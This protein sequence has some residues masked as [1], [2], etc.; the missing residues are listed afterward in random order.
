MNIFSRRP[1]SL[2]LCIMLGGFSVFA[3]LDSDYKCLMFLLPLFPLPLLFIKSLKHLRVITALASV[4]LLVSILSSYLY[5]DLW[6]KAYDR[7]DGEEIILEGEVIAVGASEY[8]STIDIKTYSINDESLTSYKIIVYIDHEKHDLPSV[9][10]VLTLSGILSGFDRTKSG[11][12]AKAYYFSN[13]YNAEIRDP[14]LIEITG[15]VEPQN[16]SIL[17]GIRNQISYKIKHI[18]NTDT[19]G[20]FTALFLGDKSTLSPKLSF[21]FTRIG[22][23]HALALSGMHL[24]IIVI[25]LSRLTSV[26]GVGKKTRD[27]LVIPF[28]VFYM[29]LTGMP[30]S[31]VRAGLMLI[32]SSFLFLIAKTRDSMTTLLISVSLICIF[33]PESVFDLSLWLSAFATFGIVSMSDLPRKFVPVKSIAYKIKRFIIASFSVSFYAM[34]ATLLISILSFNTISI[35]SPLSTFI[36][37][38]PIELFLYIGIIALIFGDLIPFGRVLVFLERLISALASILSKHRF[39][40]VSSEFIILKLL[41]ILFTLAFALFLILNIKRKRVALTVLISGFLLI[42]AVSP[43]LSLIRANQHEISYHRDNKTESIIIIGEGEINLIDEDSHTSF[44]AYTTADAAFNEKLSYIDRYILTNYSNSTSDKLEKIL[45]LIKTYELYIPEPK[46]EKEKDILKE[47]KTLAEIHSV[48]II[49][50]KVNEEIDLGI[51]TY[52]QDLRLEFTL[53]GSRNAF[54]LDHNGELISYFSSNTLDGRTRAAAASVIAKSDYVIFGSHGTSYDDYYLTYDLKNARTIVFSS[55]NMKISPY[56]LNKYKDKELY[57]EP[58]SL[59][60]IR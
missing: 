13:G 3:L 49:T 33:N 36:F 1:L 44:S 12:D 51:C 45:S 24:A 5:F 32:I 59:E 25:G 2:I 14:L 42:T 19:A 23:S 47:L 50:Y 34:S 46:N 26:F 40:S 43:L 4:A 37:A 8:S 28:T 41:I 27:A 22:L 57:Y 11:F 15:R 17:I 29:L 16:T 21:D 9:G 35:I 58:E 20:L 31:V 54:T 48:I 38:L 56:V 18:T 52:N 60:I 7:F 6:F 55:K 30:V 39:V 53:D 10:D